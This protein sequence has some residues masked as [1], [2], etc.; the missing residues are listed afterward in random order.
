M[1]SVRA[2]ILFSVEDV[3]GNGFGRV[4]FETIMFV[5]HGGRGGGWRLVEDLYFVKSNDIVI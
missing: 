4:F 2:Q 1:R 3:S 5:M